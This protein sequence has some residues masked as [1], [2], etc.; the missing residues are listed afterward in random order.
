MEAKKWNIS[1]LLACVLLL[2][3]FALPTV[4]IDPYFHFHAPYASYFLKNERYQNDGIVK[5]FSY[6]TLVTGTSMTENFKTSEVDDIFGVTSVKAPFSGASY[7]EI[8]ENTVTTI[9]YKP[10][11]EF[12]IRGLDVGRLDG[13]KDVM[14]YLDT[15]TYLY[16]ENPFNDVNYVLNKSIFFEATYPNYLLIKNGGESTSF[17]DYVNW[18]GQFTYGKDAVLETYNREEKVAQEYSMT[19]VDRERVIAN[20]EQN[21]LETVKSNPQITFYYFL[22]PYSIVWWDSINQKGMVKYQIE[23]QR[24]VLEQLLLYSNLKVYSWFNDF[25]LIESLD[26][27]KDYVY[28]SGEVNSKMLLWMKEGKGELKEDNYKEYLEEIENFY[29]NYNYNSLFI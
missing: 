5:H 4:V 13:E 10:D 26:N 20:I 29:L 8:N 22:T 3:L 1:V 21:V 27:Y 25:G 14:N 18:A 7:K 2:V 23:V 9:K 12:I 6:N 11:L 28:Y 16:D 15:P 24:V 17:D 19:D